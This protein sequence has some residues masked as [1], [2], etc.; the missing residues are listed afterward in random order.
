MRC[1]G[2]ESVRDICG[3]HVDGGVR[4]AQRYV[5]TETEIM[6][7]LGDACSLTLNKGGGGEYMLCAQRMR[8]REIEV[9]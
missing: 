1:Q 8:G 7:T 5:S 2:I 4:T 9:V 3:S 6:V